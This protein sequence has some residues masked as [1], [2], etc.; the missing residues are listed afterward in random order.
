MALSEEKR[1]Q[2]RKYIEQNYIPIMEEASTKVLKNKRSYEATEVYGLLDNED[3]L[4][5]KI[6]KYLDDT[7]Q[8]ALFDIINEKC[9]D[10]VEVYKRGYLT[11]QTFS[12]IRNDAEYHPDKDTAIR[13]CIGLKLNLDETLDL[14]SKAGYTLSRSLERDLIIRFFIENKEYDIIEIDCALED[15][16]LK[17]FLKY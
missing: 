5:R 14:L 6:D 17:Q 9:L 10:E 2:I 13:L 8:T 7:W 3:A 4:R 11:K 12:K 16:G 1:L 15:N